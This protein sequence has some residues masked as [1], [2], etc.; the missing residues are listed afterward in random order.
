VVK[1]A[2]IF[3]HGLFLNGA[4]FTLLRR[5]LSAAH[6]LETHRFN[7]PTVTGSMEQAV[8]A[9]GR[10]VASIDAERIHFVAHSLGGVVLCNYFQ[11][12]RDPRTGR[13]VMLG[14]PLG[15]S[16]SARAVAKHAV[17]R[18]VV[19]RIVAA[20][21]LAEREPRT[22]TSVRELGLVAGTRPMGLGRF[23]AR[24]DEDCDGTVA[25]SETK[26]PG[27]KDHVTV[28]ASHMG[29]LVSPVVARQV[30]AF[31]DSGAFTRPA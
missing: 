18:R 16:R 2:A 11:D 15:G 12:D 7:Y 9:L 19:G 26:L 24:F 22:W 10:L 28:A 23:F 1:T 25:V 17:L 30:G 13:V 4:E 14:S 3:V 29:M 31:L 8:D 21:L 20:E 5:R 6:G 27:Y